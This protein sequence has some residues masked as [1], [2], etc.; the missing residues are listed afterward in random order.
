MTAP[1]PRRSKHVAV[2]SMPQIS[3]IEPI[4]PSLRALQA[5]GVRVTIASE[6]ELLRHLA[7]QGFELAP[8]ETGIDPKRWGEA[9]YAES[10]QRLSGSVGAIIG[11]VR[12]LIPRLQ[13]DALVVD[14]MLWGAACAA[15]LSGLPWAGLA[16]TPVLYPTR[17]RVRVGRE[18]LTLGGLAEGGAAFLS[19]YYRVHARALIQLNV[20]R[21]RS[22]LR[23]VYG[24]HQLGYPA[25]AVL[26]YT[27]RDFEYR[28]DWHPNARFVGA[29]ASPEERPRPPFITEG[30]RVIL[31]T[32]STASL[33]GQEKILSATFEAFAEDDRYQVVATAPSGGVT[34]VPRNAY[35]QPF[36][37]HD[38]VLPFTHCVVCHGGA[39][40]VHRAMLY[41]VPLVTIP[42]ARDQ[43]EI[44]ARVRRSGV[45]AVVALDQVNPESIRDAVQLATTACRPALA[46]HAKHLRSMNGLEIATRELQNLVTPGRGDS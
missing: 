21:V 11:R 6:P 34:S 37:P 35:V 38:Q 41:E 45:G 23:P 27:S 31:V 2:L 15:E 9:P 46:R 13:I 26:I 36:I 19:Q 40:L 7:L 42:I 14:L 1:D 43:P 29:M 32:G 5:G 28:A 12:D 4:L 30:R 10:L 16:H 18:P 3:H 39:G 22:G 20:A 44:A 25:N 8:F 17:G 24:A 33:P